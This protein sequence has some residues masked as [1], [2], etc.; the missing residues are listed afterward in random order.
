MSTADIIALG[1]VGLGIVLAIGGAAWALGL[2][3]GRQ[4]A[5]IASVKG[6]VESIREET[7]WQSRALLRLFRAR[8]GRYDSEPPERPRGKLLT[9][10][11]PL[12]K[13]HD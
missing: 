7:R 10:D 4:D 13:D 2:R 11:D 6:D 1:G 5:D 3:L 9:L 12:E 8:A